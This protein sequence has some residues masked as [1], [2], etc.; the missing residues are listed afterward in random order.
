[1]KKKTGLLEAAGGD[2]GCCY[3]RI[4]LQI[5]IINYFLYTEWERSMGISLWMHFYSI[6]W[7][8]IVKKIQAFLLYNLFHS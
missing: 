2:R 1:M 6:L 5:N 4:F 7:S 3:K 8:L